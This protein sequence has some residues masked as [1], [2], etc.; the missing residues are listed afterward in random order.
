MKRKVNLIVAVLLVVAMFSALL[1]IKSEALSYSGSSSYAS[2][3]YYRALTNVQ[4]TGNQRTDIVNIAKSQI[5]YQEGAIALCETG[6]NLS[7]IML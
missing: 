7:G 4:L 2:G 5:G 3:K 6:C 1:P